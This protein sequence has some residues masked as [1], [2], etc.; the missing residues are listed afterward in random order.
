MTLHHG[1][2]HTHTTLVWVPRCAACR[3]RNRFLASAGIAGYAALVIAAAIYLAFLA[4]RGLGYS[5]QNATITRW[6]V[7]AAVLAIGF[8]LAFI[9][10]PAWSWRAYRKDP[11]V[12]WWR[13]RGWH[14][15]DSTPDSR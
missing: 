1:G 7:I 14:F 4:V 3:R 6:F 10:G 11:Q 8:V 13:D 12:A 2:L 5:G 9:I 15:I